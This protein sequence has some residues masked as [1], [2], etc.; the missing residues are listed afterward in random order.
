VENLLK[1]IVILWLIPFSSNAKDFGILGQTFPIAEK[2]PIE[3]IRER[4]AKLEKSGELAILQKKWQD[5]SV[6]RA[7]RPKD[8]LA[9]I[10]KVDKDQVRYFDPSIT[11]KQNLADHQ[12]RV[13]AYAGQT[14]NPFDKL[15]NYFLQLIFIDGDDEEQ[16]EFALGKNRLNSA[17]II[18]VRGDIIDLMQ[19]HKI[20]MYFDQQGLLVKKFSLDKFPTIIQ[21]EGK[22]LKIQEVAL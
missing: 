8:S 2:D 22:K 9:V 6:K 19:K 11:V 18:L 14:V 1:I 20:R 7:K 4:L 13:F 12:G 5:T 10:K 3:L 15:P 17:K 21:R 16:V